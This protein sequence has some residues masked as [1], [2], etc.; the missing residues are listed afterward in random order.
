[1]PIEVDSP[2]RIFTKDEF[3]KL[4]H[5]IMGIVF[6]VHNEFGRLMNES[7]YKNTIRKRCE[8]AGIR[9]AKRE[10]KITV[11][12]QGF[13]KEYFMDLLFCEGL[14]VEGKTVAKLTQAHFAQSLHYL[15]L[16]GMRDGLL[17]NLRPDSVEKEF[18]STTLDLNQRRQI[19]LYVN[20][21][22]VVSDECD[23]WRQLLLE[24]LT[25]WGAFLEIPLYCDAMVHFYGGTDAVRRRIPIYDGNTLV[26]THEVCLLDENTAFAITGLKT[27]QL[28]MAAHFQ[29][30]LNHTKLTHLQW[31]NMN[32]H[33]IE[34]R[35]IKR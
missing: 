31:V 13:L 6:D 17:V 16:T 28:T 23:R 11:S 22:I 21:W 19:K 4:A 1:M 26:G 20:E 18:V 10:V 2:I 29:R 33:D 34:F 5:Q 12:F 3:H 9:P 14:M 35:T 32:N 27:K 24:L 8:D 30:F 7:V 15:M 25:E